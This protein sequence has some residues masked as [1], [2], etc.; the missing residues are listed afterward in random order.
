MT[1]LSTHSLSLHDQ[2]EQ[3]ADS[4]YVSSTPDSNAEVTSNKKSESDMHRKMKNGP[5]KKSL[6]LIMQ[7]AA[8]LQIVNLNN[9]EQLTIIGN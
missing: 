8:A 1:K 5:S 7:F 9:Q 3:S 2:I 6:M 4:Q